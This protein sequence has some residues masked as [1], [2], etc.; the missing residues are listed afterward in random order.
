MSLGLPL[1]YY[2]SEVDLPEYLK[3][4]YEK[5]IDMVRLLMIE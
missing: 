3:N 5:G 4:E 1:K 2:E